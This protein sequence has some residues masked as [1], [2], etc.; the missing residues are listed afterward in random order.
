MSRNNNNVQFKANKRQVHLCTEESITVR[1]LSFS[2]NSEDEIVLGV[3]SASGWLVSKRLCSTKKLSRCSQP[4]LLVQLSSNNKEI[5]FC[6]QKRQIRK[7]RWQR[8]N[9]KNYQQNAQAS[10]AV[11]PCL[12]RCHSWPKWHLFGALH[13]WRPLHASRFVNHYRLFLQGKR[14]TW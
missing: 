8:S 6:L 12:D 11:R 5:L 3:F 14:R 13:R 7:L 2:W 10:S 4:T 9:Q 1:H